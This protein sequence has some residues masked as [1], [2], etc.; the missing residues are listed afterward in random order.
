VLKWYQVGELD[1][2]GGLF[3]ATLSQFLPM[4]LVGFV[5]GYFY[6]KTD[7]LWVPWIA[8]YLNNTVFNLLH[9]TT[10]GGLDSGPALRG[11]VSLIVSL[12]GMFLVKY[13]SDRIQMSEVKPWGEWTRY[14]LATE[15]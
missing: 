11:P 5:W 1:A 10:A 2:H 12:L 3:V 6:L 14:D 4:L 9:I 13:A 8:H 7:S 15:A